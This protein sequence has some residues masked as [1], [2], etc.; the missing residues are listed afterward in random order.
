M[1]TPLVGDKPMTNAERQA[2]W[3][4]RYAAK[5]ARKAARRGGHRPPTE[6]DIASWIITREDWDRIFVRPDEVKP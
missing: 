3:R 6:E 1:S 4:K 2:R 5:L